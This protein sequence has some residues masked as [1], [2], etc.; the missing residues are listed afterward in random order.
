MTGAALLG[1]SCKKPYDYDKDLGT[2]AYS[3]EKLNASITGTWRMQQA[4]QV[5]EKTLIRESMDITDFLTAGN[6]TAPN[7]RFDAAS[8]TFSV[9]TAGLLINYFV[10][11]S[12]KWK[13]DDDRYP[14]RIILMDQNDTETSEISI[15]KNLLS[16]APQL[17]FIQSI[18][19]SGEKAIS[20]NI[21]FTK[22]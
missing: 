16:P 21:V 17:M 20:Y 4:L 22:N 6:A 14:A 7:I 19:C 5:D 1:V 2:P 11:P 10:I 8:R 13:F 18:D 12:G 15:G 3:V 9:D